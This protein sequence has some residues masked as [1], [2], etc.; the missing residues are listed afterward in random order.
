MNVVADAC[1]PIDPTA[2]SSA[3]E[4][5]SA[6][7]P[8][9][10][11]RALWGV[12]A[13]AVLIP[14]LL[15]GGAT[16]VDRS[17]VLHRAEQDGRKTVALLHEQ[18]ANLLGGHEIILDTIVERVRGHDWATIEASQELL[19]DLVNMDNRLD[20]ASAILLIDTAGTVRATTLPLEG[21]GASAVPDR[22]CFVALSE[23][24]STSCVSRRHVDPTSG[25]NLFSLCRRLEEGGQF[26]GVAQVAISA[27]YFL[28]LWKAIAPDAGTTII[29]LRDDGVVLARYPRIPSQ[30]LWLPPDAPLMTG[31]KQGG[32]GIV[33]LHERAQN[34]DQITLYKKVSSYPVYISVGLDRNVVLA[35]WHH[36]LLVYGVVALVATLALVA[37]AGVALGRAQR[38]RRA[39]ALWQAEVKERE[40]AQQKL[41]ESQVLERLGQKQIAI[42]RDFIADAAHELRTPLSV[43]R[44]RVDTMKDQEIAQYLRSDIGAMGRTV[45]QLLDI[46]QSE[47]LVVGAD[48]YADLQSVCSETV[49]HLA[50]LALAQQK[51]VALTGAEQSVWV[52]GSTEALL[53][54][55]RN[56]LENAL[57]H[58]AVGTSAEIDVDASGVIRVSDH[59]PGVAMHERELVFRRFW[60]RDRRRTGSAGLGLSIVSKIVEAH[61]GTITV[62]DREGGGAVFTLALASALIP[63]DKMG[64]IAAAS[65]G[66]EGLE[67][68]ESMS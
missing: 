19:N 25:R 50:P 27:D 21:G 51:D 14:V 54:A 11:V 24:R 13:A 59:G 12:A 65:G 33:R 4:K 43:L 16:L 9:E 47:T 30:P 32:E 67:T 26:K 2:S 61:G 55:V 28:D 18:A 46:A 52:R 34:A 22:D 29:L 45:N 20:D 39:V 23:G 1:R 66:N 42:Q 3:R 5:P 7:T 49:A 62:G 41:F 6:G 15:F 63:D 53:H 37:A 64:S 44:V 35:E 8:N 36:N 57:A 10:T 60:R 40:A 48:E 17:A 58:T 38:E 68:A 31:L 56:L